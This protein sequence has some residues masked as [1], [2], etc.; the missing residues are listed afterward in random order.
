[1]R[2]LL[3]FLLFSV[4]CNA[5][6]KKDKYLEPKPLAKIIKEMGEAEVFVYSYMAKDSSKK[7]DAELF[8]YYDTIFAINN[9]TKKQ[10]ASSVAYYINKPKEFKTILDSA[11]ANARTIN[12]F[13]DKMSPAMVQ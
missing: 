1:M 5:C 7:L 13:Q 8:K 2:L 3:L 12:Y 6:N 11:Q 9:T 4:F 10:F